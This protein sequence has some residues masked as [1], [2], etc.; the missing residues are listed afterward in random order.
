MNLETYKKYV[1]WRVIPEAYGYTLLRA[2]LELAEETME[3]FLE[4]TV[5]EL[6]DVFFWFSYLANALE[7]ELQYEEN[8]FINDE[9]LNFGSMIHFQDLMEAAK[10]VVGDIKRMYRD[11]NVRKIENLKLVTLPALERCLRFE[12][13]VA[14]KLDVQKVIDYN[15]E[16]LDKRFGNTYD[17]Q[18]N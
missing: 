2:G 10:N 12:I 13:H 8:P 14:H 5:D 6:G 4:P 16:K 7:Y 11:N 3:Y 9:V 15:V 1:H 17:E 18:N